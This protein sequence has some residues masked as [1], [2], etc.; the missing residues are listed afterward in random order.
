MNYF[1]LD[2]NAVVK[3][4]IIEEGTPLMEYFFNQVPPERMIIC[5]S[6]TVGE[7]LSIFKSRSNIYES[8]PKNSRGITDDRYEELKRLFASEVSRHPQVVKVYPTNTQIDTIE[9]FID[10]HPIKNTDATVLRC[11]L[12]KANEL[13]PDGHNLILVSSDK[14]LLKA[15][16][17]EKL[18]TFNPLTNKPAYLDDLINS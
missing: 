8:D 17:S 2:A 9:E 18:D 13:R 15:S 12:D 3:R 14:G 10:R 4:Y 11:A 7:V 1:W 5:M 6:A 16:K